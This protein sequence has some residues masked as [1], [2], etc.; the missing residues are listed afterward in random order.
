LCV[1]PARNSRGSSNSNVGTLNVG[2]ISV[3]EGFAAR[4]IGADI[5]SLYLH[6]GYIWVHSYACVIFIS[7]NQIACS[8]R[9]SAN[10][11]VGSAD[12]DA[13]IA[14]GKDCVTRDISADVVSLHGHP[15]GN[16]VN[17]H[18]VVV[19]PRNDIASG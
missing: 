19:I 1:S 11:N 6:T 5:V 4:D 9:G 12:L 15:G 13:N 2:T 3:G 8:G 14:V 17:K 18:A 10:Y 16:A 7:R